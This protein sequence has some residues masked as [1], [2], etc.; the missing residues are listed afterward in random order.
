[1]RVEE[2][3][4][5]FA[6]EVRLPIDV[7]DILRV[8]RESGCDDDIEFIAVDL[9]TEVLQGAIKVCHVRRTMYGDPERLVN[10]YFH[11]GHSLAWQRFIACKELVHVLD[12]DGSRVATPED[13]RRLAEKI[14]LPPEMQDPLNDGF[15][16]NTDRLAEWRATALLFP[17]ACRELLMPAYRDGRLK[18]ADIARLVDIPSRYAGFVMSDGWPAIYDILA[19]RGPGRSAA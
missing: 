6:G 4:N 5:Q 7:N 11:R 1:M 13:A 14:G 18:L 3:I 16:T 19:G 8:L 15:A 2:L 12:P 17:M 9:D 10:I